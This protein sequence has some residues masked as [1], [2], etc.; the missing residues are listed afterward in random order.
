MRLLHT[1]RIRGQVL[2]RRL[3][4]KFRNI[5]SPYSRLISPR[6]LWIFG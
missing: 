3:I 1:C 4:E 5:L 6:N 2:L